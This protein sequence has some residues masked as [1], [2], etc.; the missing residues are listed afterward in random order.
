MCLTIQDRANSL[1]KWSLLA[2]S[3]PCIEHGRRSRKTKRDEHPSTLDIQQQLAFLQDDLNANNIR[4]HCD[5]R[6]TSVVVVLHREASCA[7]TCPMHRKPAAERIPPKVEVTATAWPNQRAFV[8]P[9]RDHL[10]HGWWRRLLNGRQRGGFSASRICC[11][12][13]DG[14]S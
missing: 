14:G 3:I 4:S 13:G 1:T 8:S 6:R 12:D 9:G 11:A 2:P 5:L 7:E 10:N